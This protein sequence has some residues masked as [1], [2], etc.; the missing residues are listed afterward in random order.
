[1]MS[2]TAKI[3]LLAS[4]ALPVSAVYAA[5]VKS[6]QAVFESDCSDCHSVKP[7]VNKTGPSLAGVIGRHAGTAA[8]Y[9]YSAA[10]KGSNVT[11]TADKVEAFV[12]TPRKTV[13]GTKMSYEGL[14]DAKLRKDLIAYLQTQK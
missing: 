1:M 5:D 2:R 14:P 3:V 4:I 11:W 10:M 13:A 7:G 8:K 6:G 12:T 9:N